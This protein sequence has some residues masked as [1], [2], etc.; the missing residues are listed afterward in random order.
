MK[1]LLV[2]PPF[3]EVIPS[4]GKF[5]DYV[6]TNLHFYIDGS[7]PTGILR[8][9]TYL[10]RMGHDVKLIDCC[11]ESTSENQNSIYRQKL[12]GKRLN[13]IGE[14]EDYYHF[15]LGYDEFKE[16]LKAKD[17]PDEIWITTTMTYHNV[18]VHKIVKICKE[19]FPD[20]SVVIGGIYASICP[21]D[22][23]MSGADRIHIGE[24]EP[25]NDCP[26]DLSLLDYVPLYAV[27]KST[28]GCPNKCSYCA[29]QNLEGRK[30]RFRDYR[31][32]ITEMCEKI[33]KYKITHFVFWES[34]LLVNGKEHFEKILD[35]IIEKKIRVSLFTPEGLQ[36]SL[37]YEELAKKMYLAG[38]RTLNLPL[39]SVDEDTC[40]NRFKRKT[41]LKEFLLAVDI[42]NKAGFKKKDL[43]IFVLIGMPEEDISTIIKSMLT[44]WE[45][46]C[47]VILMPFTPIPG[48]EE[49][50]K[51]FDL[52]K[53]R[54]L[55]ELHP[56][57]FPFKNTKEKMSEVKFLMELNKTDSPFKKIIDFDKNNKHL[58][59]LSKDLRF[60]KLLYEH[61]NR[62]K[63]KNK[64]SPDNILFELIKDGA[65]KCGDKIIF[66]ENDNDLNTKYLT[67]QGI[68]ITNLSL[69]KK[70]ITNSFTITNAFRDKYTPGNYDVVID[71]SLH[72]FESLPLYGE[73]VLNLLKTNGLYIIKKL[74]NEFY[75]SEHYKDFIDIKNLYDSDS[76]YYFE[77]MQIVKSMPRHHYFEKN[78]LLPAETVFIFRKVYKE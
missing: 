60:T 61:V 67:E 66:V 12:A 13:G 46:G 52:I 47:T 73:E 24:F 72:N 41:G 45:L 20:T 43:D 21:E 56:Y 14:P 6:G 19:I 55:E 70:E 2:R 8:I 36:P 64:M 57:L 30:M 33:E 59:K 35:E 48:T 11:A 7:Q 28:R 37:V 29:V 25:A 4:I 10:K 38:F 69:N 77:N 5:K 63:A 23:K 34:N 1:I 50:I 9:G 53:H 16:I 40:K 22:A 49:Y 3:E 15:G 62:L 65:I 58:I 39:E 74:S 68:E 17:T 78:N 76:K 31:D 42:F 32:V 75:K 51:Y 26:T 54:R 71:L 18:S 44:I 27:I